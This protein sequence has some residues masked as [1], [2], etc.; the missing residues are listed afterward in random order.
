MITDRIEA[1]HLYDGI[2]PRVAAALSFARNTDFAALDDGRYDVDGDRLFALVQRYT[3]KPI[4]QGAWEAHRRYA[5]LQCVICGAERIGYGPSP[6][7]Q[8]G[9]YQADKDISFGTGAGDLVTIGAGSFMLLWPGE[10]HMP[11]IADGE[12]GLVLKVVVKIACP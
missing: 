7:F 10:V 12:P 3:S 6:R 8:M 11:Q 1:A 9:A 5:D 2:G 4:E